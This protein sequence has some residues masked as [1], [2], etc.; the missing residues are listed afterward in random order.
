[1]SLAQIES[2]AVNAEG[3][4]IGEREKMQILDQSP[5][6]SD[7]LRE[8]GEALAFERPHTILKRFDLAPQHGERCPQLV[9]DVGDPLLP[10][11]TRRGERVSELV[12]VCG[13]LVELIVPSDLKARVVF[14]ADERGGCCGNGPDAL[15]KPVSQA[16]AERER[17]CQHSKRDRPESPV[18]LLR[19][20]AVDRLHQLRPRHRSEISDDLAPPDDRS[21][22]G[23]RREVGAPDEKPAPGV[24][25]EQSRIDRERKLAR[26]RRRGRRLTRRLSSAPR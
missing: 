17:G 23:L 2:F 4:E 15:R 1:M 19:E 21:R 3:T 25:Q 12:E 7:F 16:G 14:A 26:C 10:S 5:E 13:E 6:A 8:R 24:E 11:A 18:L 22:H 9:R 20:H